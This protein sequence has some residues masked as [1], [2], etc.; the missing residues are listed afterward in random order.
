MQPSC[1]TKYV[2]NFTL[3][4]P[5]NLYVILARHNE[6]HEDGILNLE[7]CNSMLFVFIVFDIIVQSL[8]KL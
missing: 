7:T 6:L 8:V 5:E 1:S 3:L 2:N 4:R